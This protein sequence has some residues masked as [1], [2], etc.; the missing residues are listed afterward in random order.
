MKLKNR[1]LYY[2]GGI[3]RDEIL[4]IKSLDTDYCFEG[5]A[6]EFARKEKLNIVR[7]NTA[8][9]TVRIILNN[10]QIDIAST[11]KESYPRKGHLPKIE[12]IGCSLK[13]DLKRRDFTVNAM[14]K[15]TTDGELIDFFGGE[16]DIRQKCL[17]I[18]HKNSFIDDPTRIIRGLKFSVRFGFQLDNET[19]ELQNKYLENIN[20]DISWHRL[21][22]ELVETFGLNKQKAYDK[23]INE[24]IYK[25][26]GKNQK[27]PPIEWNIEEI[28]SEYPSKY[29]WLVYL[30]QFDLSNLELTRAE[31]RI[32]E[33]KERLL[34]EPPANN[35]PFE[36]ILIHKL[37]V[38]R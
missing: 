29:T 7:E 20:Y 2:V 17:K 18:L 31:K 13:E 30:S 14:A 25:L 4:G 23:F 11:R 21:K 24:G 22:K 6:I 34:N 35:T 15:R 27:I 37:M 26:L 8:F 16:E 36:S 32:L 38:C 28:M 19:L 5:D 33:W 3:V 12:K 1:D 9:G 10:S